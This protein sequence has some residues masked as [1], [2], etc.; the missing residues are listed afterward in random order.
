MRS[1]IRDG[2][3]SAGA[4]AVA[5][6][7]LG[8]CQ[9]VNPTATAH[10]DV[11]L[12]S[13]AGGVACLA[14]KTLAER[15]EFASADR[16]GMILRRPDVWA[17]QHSAFDR[18]A[19]MR[20]LEPT[21]TQGFLAFAADAGLDWTPAE[22]AYWTM[23][24]DRLSDALAGLNPRVPQIFMVKTTGLEEFNAAYTRNQSIMLPRERLDIAGDERRD[25][26]LIA[27]EFF[28][29][30]STENPARRSELY[31]LLGFQRFARFEYP[32]ELE[33]RRLSN[34][35]AHHN[36][37]ALAVQT[38]DGPRDVV[39]V[40][41]SAVPLEDIIELPTSGPPAIFGVLDIVLLPVDIG[42]GAVLRDASGAP[43]RYGFGSSSWV[44]QMQRNSTYIIHPEELMADNF[45][46]LMEWRSSGVI[47]AATP[48]GFPVNDIALL[49]AIEEVLSAGCGT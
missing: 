21:T 32:A 16:A 37:H 6:L 46:L 26:F 42:T 17:R 47:P 24:A 8:A 13:R 33:E 19:R 36:E 11:V 18:G 1:W 31:A 7:L 49:T 41:Q 39:P 27:H 48:S 28:H 29:V 45:A 30:L 14:K 4:T 9:G 23:L 20:T 34:P 35:Q 25:F 43:I 12:Q 10:S 15:L 2:A 38:P 40:L 5:A 44:S 3:R 22:Q